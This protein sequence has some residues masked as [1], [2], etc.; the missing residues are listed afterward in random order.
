MVLTCQ[1]LDEVEFSSDKGPFLSRNSKGPISME[2]QTLK[3]GGF[4]K[5]KNCNA[6]VLFLNF[7]LGSCQFRESR[8]GSESCQCISRRLYKLINYNST[9][10]IKRFKLLNANH[11]I[12]CWA[13]KSCQRP[14]YFGP[15][16]F[17]KPRSPWVDNSI[18]REVP[19]S[20]SI[21]K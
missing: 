17:I 20:F 4:W 9:Y 8:V 5:T 13:R 15:K 19:F 7:I 2:K 16:T 21:T 12:S 14:N 11:L 6:I 3:A 18:V 10:L 1:F